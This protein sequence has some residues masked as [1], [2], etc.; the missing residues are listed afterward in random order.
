MHTLTVFRER[1]GIIYALFPELPGSR[2]PKECLA[3][4][5]EKSFHAV[6]YDS[7][8]FHSRAVKHKAYRELLSELRSK[9][10]EPNIIQQASIVMHERRKRAI[11]DQKSG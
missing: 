7:F 9:G 1:D 11:E 6:D 4:C 3:Y 2:K 8:M 5:T 10:Y